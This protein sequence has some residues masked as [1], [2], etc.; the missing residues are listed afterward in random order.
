MLPSALAEL[1]MMFNESID[2]YKPV[3]SSTLLSGNTA[4]FPAGPFWLQE[5]RSGSMS[6]LGAST[7]SSAFHEPIISRPV[8][9]AKVSLELPNTPP[10]SDEATQRLKFEPTQ[11]SPSSSMVSGQAG[12]LNGQ[13]VGVNPFLENELETTMKRPAVR[14][15][16][17]MQS[18]APRDHASSAS[19]VH[20]RGQGESPVSKTVESENL[21]YKERLLKGYQHQLVGNYDEAMQDYRLVIRGAPELLGEVI[22]NLRALLKLAPRYSIGYRV[23]GDAYMHQGEY[24]QAMDAYNSAL[25]MAK[26]ARS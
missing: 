21:N 2:N 17:M 12:V 18:V 13:D 10:V 4:D 1:G 6:E 3:V 15:Q 11:I 25:T 7:T 5:L 26:K 24:L 20:T 23:L 14:L 19:Q 22:S 16:S 8:S 9:P